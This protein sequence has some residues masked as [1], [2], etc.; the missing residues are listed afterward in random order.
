[1]NFEELT[2][3]IL[4][5]NQSEYTVRCLE[6]LRPVLNDGARCILI[7]NASTDDTLEKVRGMSLP[8]LTVMTLDK[9]MG[10]APARNVGLKA[11]DEATKFVLILDNDTIVD[12]TSLKFMLLYMKDHPDFG[13]LG[14]RLVSPRGVIQRSFKRFPG[15]GEKVR[16]LLYDKSTVN[17]IPQ[18]VEPFYVIGACQMIRRSLIDKIGYLDER[19]FFGP[20]DAD[21]CMR[22]RKAGYKVIYH[23]DAIIVHDWQRK[24]RKRPFSRIARKHMYGLAYFY[25]KYHRVW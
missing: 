12:T 21:Y 13:I 16:N 2:I 7:D 18:A 6:S 4:T 9:N 25:M 19:I 3:I 1:M 10:V 14:P 17:T 15:I 23:P 22:A 5:C 11:I 20:E 8:G 24:S